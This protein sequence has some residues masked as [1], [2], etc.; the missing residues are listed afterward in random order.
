MLLYMLGPTGPSGPDGLFLIRVYT[1]KQKGPDW[2]RGRK[3]KT[4]AQFHFTGVRVNAT[5]TKAQ[6]EKEIR[7]ALARRGV[8]EH[9]LHIWV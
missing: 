4:I 9:A 2:H 6:T 7:Q 5:K 8:Q 3:T 1:G